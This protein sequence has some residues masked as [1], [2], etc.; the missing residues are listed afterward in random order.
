MA[1]GYGLQIDDDAAV[2]YQE[3]T[4]VNVTDEVAIFLIATVPGSKPRRYR[5][6]PY[7]HA[8]DRVNLPDGYAKKYQG[9]GKELCTPIIERLTRREVYPQGPLRHD[10]IQN[11]MLPM[12][13]AGPRLPR[14]VHEDQADAMRARWKTAM[15]Q[16]GTVK[17]NRPVMVQLEVGADQIPNRARIKPSEKLVGE[18]VGQDEIEPDP[19]LEDEVIATGPPSEPP[20]KSAKGSK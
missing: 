15:Q 12:Y 1:G 13:P 19:D 9:A 6:A 14:V 2:D 18:E 10:Q 3:S 4:I 17:G 7:G 8:G 11:K 16:H 5:L 20:A